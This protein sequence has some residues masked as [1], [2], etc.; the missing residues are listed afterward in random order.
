[1]AQ[2]KSSLFSIEKIGTD[3]IRLFNNI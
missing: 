2:E 1:M 3:W